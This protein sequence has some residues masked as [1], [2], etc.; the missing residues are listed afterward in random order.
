MSGKIIK[1][2]GAFTSVDSTGVSSPNKTLKEL[3]TEV[4]Q[5]FAAEPMRLAASTVDFSVPFGTITAA[6]RIY[7][8]SDQPI[9]LKVNLNTETG[10]QWQGTGILPSGDTGISALF[11][12]TGASITTLEVVIAGD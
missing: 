8:K 3:D 12:S 5:V 2:S 7:L 11:V 1:I 4:D 10:F 9:T 6:R